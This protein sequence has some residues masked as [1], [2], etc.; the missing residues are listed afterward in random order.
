VLPSPLGPLYRKNNTV[1]HQFIKAGTWCFHQHHSRS[2]KHEPHAR[3]LGPSLD[4][5][6]NNQARPWKNHVLAQTAR[7]L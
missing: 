4:V 3:F 5:H 2:A 7:E 6:G 1:K